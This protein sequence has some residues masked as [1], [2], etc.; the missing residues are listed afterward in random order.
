MDDYH[1]YGIPYTNYNQA[2]QKMMYMDNSIYNEADFMEEINRLEGEN[3]ILSNENFIGRSLFY[4]HSNRSK[5]A[6]RLQ[7]AMPD[8][9]SFST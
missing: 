2:F 4:H 5:I 9:T 8:A 1:Y 3:I 7:K 6:R